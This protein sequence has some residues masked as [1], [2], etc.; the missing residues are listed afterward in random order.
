MS[1][2]LKGTNDWKQLTFYFNSKDRTQI[3]VG[4]RLGSYSDNCKG[5]A[6]FKDLKLERGYL[7]ED[8]NW[9][10]VCFIFENLDVNV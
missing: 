4:F 10:M 9:N 5:E 2:V 1:E 8:T 7:T 6:W 3:Q